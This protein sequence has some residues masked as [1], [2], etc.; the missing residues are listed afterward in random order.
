MTADSR[1]R[2]VRSAA[3]LI[4]RRGATAASFNEVLADSGAPRG[5]IYHHFPKGKDELTA[6]AMQLVAGYVATRQ[7]ACA[8]TS[9]REVLACFIG[10]W[11]EVVVASG[12]KAGCAIAGTAIDAENDALVA[13]AR[14]AFHQWIDVLAA[15]FAATGVSARETRAL[16]TTTV[17]ALEGALILCRTERSA[18][19][20]DIVARNLARL[21][22]REDD[23]PPSAPKKKARR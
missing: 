11:R 13:V 14:A 18:A 10:M 8:A 15:Q 9:P 22:P 2:M 16:A 21:L 17:A 4:A 23:A 1:N 19:P 3:E 20:L 6:A 7:Q 12:G 5:S